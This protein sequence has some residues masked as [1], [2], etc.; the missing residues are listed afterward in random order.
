MEPATVLEDKVLLCI[1]CHEEFVF[2]VSAQEYFA[3]KGMRDDPRWCKS[4]YHRR[5]TTRTV[6]PRG[7]KPGGGDDPWSGGDNGVPFEAFDWPPD[8]YL[9]QR[10]TDRRPPV[11]PATGGKREGDS[12]GQ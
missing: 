12:G 11:D 5:R 8:D 7:R 10:R 6:F 3:S 4:C 2:T 1:D 9:S